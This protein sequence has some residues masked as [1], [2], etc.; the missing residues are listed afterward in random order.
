M[1]LQNDGEAR[2][3]GYYWSTQEKIET[4]GVLTSIKVNLLFFNGKK[5]VLTMEEISE[6][7]E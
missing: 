3:S 6:E 1:S 7:P 4:D 2:D 5:F